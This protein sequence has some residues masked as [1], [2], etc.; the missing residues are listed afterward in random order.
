VD[1]HTKAGDKLKN[2]ASKRN[3]N[4]PSSM[5]AKDQAFYDRYVANFAEAPEDGTRYYGQGQITFHPE[6]SRPAT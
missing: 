3:M 5:D 2:I 4:L 1:D 6:T